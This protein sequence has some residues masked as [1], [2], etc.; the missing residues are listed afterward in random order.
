MALF[1]K[2]ITTKLHAEFKDD[3]ENQML[4]QIEEVAGNFNKCRGQITDN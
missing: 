1:F 4:R 2:E 3:P